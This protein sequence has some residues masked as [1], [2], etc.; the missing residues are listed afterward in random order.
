MQINTREL[1]FQNH[2]SHNSISKTASNK[3]GD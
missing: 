3:K 1:K 2:S